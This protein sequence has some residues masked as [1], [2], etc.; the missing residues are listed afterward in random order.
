[1]PRM[2]VTALLGALLLGGC[3]ESS[4]W[5]WPDWS[6]PRVVGTVSDQFGA[7]VSNVDL[8]LVEPG[9]APYEWGPATSDGNGHFEI[10]P[11]GIVPG[12]YKLIIKTMPVGYV[13]PTTQPNPITFVWWS[14]ESSAVP[15]PFRLIL[16]TLTKEAITPGQSGE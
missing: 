6:I 9:A 12:E 13:L 3:S 15:H 4:D 16:I 10:Q 1:M 14:G 11:M 8:G 5:V 7:P 2:I